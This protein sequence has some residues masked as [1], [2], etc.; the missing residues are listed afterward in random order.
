MC[1]LRCRQDP[2][3]YKCP[4]CVAAKQ[5]RTSKRVLCRAK[6]RTFSQFMKVKSSGDGWAQVRLLQKQRTF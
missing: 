3:G 2:R 6:N 1:K 5:K 4:T